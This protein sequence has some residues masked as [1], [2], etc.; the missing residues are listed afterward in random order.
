VR[1]DRRWLAALLALAGCV[2][3][4]LTGCGGGKTPKQPPPTTHQARPDSTS[5]HSNPAD[6]PEPMPAQPSGPPI[7]RSDPLIQELRP[8]LREWT[9]M[10]RAALAGFEVDS[11]W[12]DGRKHWSASWDSLPPRTT[13]H[14][15]A[16]PWDDE[17]TAEV[18]T[19]TSPGSAFDLGIDTYQAIVEDQGE[20][21]VGGEPDSRSAL[22]DRGRNRETV[23]VFSGTMGGQHWGRWFGPHRFALAGWSDASDFGQW[24]QGWI[25]VYSGADS[26]IATYVTRVVPDTRFERYRAAWE[27][28]VVSRY[29]ALKPRPPS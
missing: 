20:V 15:G 6:R 8:G 14:G 2:S 10:W 19:V 13:K 27:K 26:S 22:Y 29:R 4:I 1:G 5:S 21:S 24:K 11:L 17:I 9:A 3:V 12:A 7:G 25:S 23:L 18:F 16:I 28:W